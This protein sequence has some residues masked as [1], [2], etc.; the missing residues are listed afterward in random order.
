MN[1]K[2]NEPWSIVLILSSLLILIGCNRPSKPPGF[3]KKLYPCDVTVVQD[4]KPL[5]GAVVRLI[6]TGDY[7]EKK[8]W[9]AGGN[10]ENT[11]IAVI[12]TYGK[13]KGIPKGTYKI[14]VTKTIEI[15][16]KGAS[17]EFEDQIPDTDLFS[18]VEKQY[19]DENLTPL[20]HE[21]TDKSAITI[22]VGKEVRERVSLPGR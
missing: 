13:W 8:D 17:V 6:P 2:S 1:K 14:T 3:P 5:H 20:L 7:G 15:P 9:A 4:E 11:G 12:H 10:T 22:D 21:V 19:T 16:K 18:L